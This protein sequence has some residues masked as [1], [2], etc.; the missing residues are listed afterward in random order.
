LQIRIPRR[1]REYTIP[2]DPKQAPRHMQSHLPDQEQPQEE[3]RGASPTVLCSHLARRNCV[4]FR[5]H[6]VAAS[7][8]AHPIRMIEPRHQ[9]LSPHQRCRDENQ[10]QLIV[11]HQD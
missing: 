7:S 6:Y 10:F 8:P 1:C 9:H 11:L 4:T 2:L 5:V 3:R